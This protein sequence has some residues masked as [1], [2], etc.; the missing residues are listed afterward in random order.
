MKDY[1]LRAD[2]RETIDQALYS[3]GLLFYVGGEPVLNVAVDYVD[4]ISRPTGRILLDTEGVEYPEQGPVEGYHANLRAALTAEQEALLP[5]IER[6][7][8]PH[9][10]F[11]GGILT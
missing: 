4:T 10:I 8:N 7:G 3:A 5:I 9:R 11:A 1:F 6:P 2:N